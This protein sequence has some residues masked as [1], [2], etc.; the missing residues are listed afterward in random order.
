VPRQ[1]IRSVEIQAPIFERQL[2]AM[3][4]YRHQVTKAALEKAMGLGARP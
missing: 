4:A 2:D 1:F 3:F